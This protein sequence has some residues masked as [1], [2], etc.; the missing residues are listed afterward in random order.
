V[1]FDNKAES[2]IEVTAIRHRREAYRRSSR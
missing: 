2:L 1:F